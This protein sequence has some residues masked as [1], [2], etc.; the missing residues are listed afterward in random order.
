MTQKSIDL[1]VDMGESFGRFR[2]GADEEIIAYI[3]SAN[4]ACGFHAGDPSVINKTVALAKTHGVAVGAHIGYPDLLGFGRRHLQ[5][6][7]SD[8]KDY[9]T[10]QIGALQAFLRAKQLSLHHVKLHGALY[11]MALEDKDCSQAIVQAILQQDKRLQVYTLKDSAL[12]EVA[13]KHDLPVIFEF[14]ADRGY[15]A[16][17]RVKMFDWNLSEAG[18]SPQAIGERIA[19]LVSESKV[20]AMDG[21]LIDMEAQTI[22]VHSDTPDSPVIARSIVQ[23]LGKA[24]VKLKAP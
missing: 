24:G 5:V 18:G 23:A 1:N 21:N 14:F 16:N 17:G 19:R 8:L 7:S 20:A 3:T 2:H 15:Y 10:Y 9:A 22:C 11:M 12:A 6:S 4:I 13:Q